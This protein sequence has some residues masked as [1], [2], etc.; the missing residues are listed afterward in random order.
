MVCRERGSDF[1]GRNEIAEEH[2]YFLMT[3]I[4]PLCAQQEKKS[5]I[6]RVP[7]QKKVRKIK[8]K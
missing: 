2:E 5:H 3:H 7:K 6:L 1:Y 8:K 4:I